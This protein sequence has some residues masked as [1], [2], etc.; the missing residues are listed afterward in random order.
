M[1]DAFAIGLK[2]RA[3]IEVFDNTVEI[4]VCAAQWESRI[5][6]FFERNSLVFCAFLVHSCHINPKIRW[7]VSLKGT[8]FSPYIKGIE[9]NGALASEGR[10]LSN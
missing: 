2:C 1:L 8:G 3:A 4:A 6:I 9:I 10:A 5:A 7:W